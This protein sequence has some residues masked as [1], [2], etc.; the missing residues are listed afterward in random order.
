MLLI[1][2]KTI[3]ATD[4]HNCHDP[5]DPSQDSL[6]L[7][8][9]ASF[10]LG[11]TES[12]QVDNL[13]LALIFALTP[14]LEQEKAEDRNSLSVFNLNSST[15]LDTRVRKKQTLAHLALARVLKNNTVS[16][17][18]HSHLT[19]LI[20]TMILRTRSPYSTWTHLLD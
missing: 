9:V 4:P 11:E 19:L 1:S 7:L 17:P 12:G 6:S 2:H 5:Q 13:V 16:D 3:H 18:Q 20:M 15:L 8:D 10:G 14:T